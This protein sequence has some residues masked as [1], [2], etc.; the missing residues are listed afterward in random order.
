MNRLVRVV[1]QDPSQG[2]DVL[3]EVALLDAD[4]SPD[5]VEELGL[6]HDLAVLRDKAGKTPLE[7][8][9][10]PDDTLNARICFSE[11]PKVMAFFNEAT[12]IVFPWEKYGQIIL[13]DHF[14][15]MENTACTT[16]NTTK[17]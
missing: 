2:R 12:G 8:F 16:M 9:V 15:G 3:R 5:L 14:G 6:V 1:S 11:T 7:Y 13:Q 4:P 10:Y 17:A